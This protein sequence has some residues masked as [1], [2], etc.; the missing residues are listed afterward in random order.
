MIKAKIIA[1]KVNM[2][3]ILPAKKE[4]ILE[5]LKLKTNLGTAPKRN[6]AT[7]GVM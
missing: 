1:S 3:L 5:N 6:E 2:R 7:I 4:W